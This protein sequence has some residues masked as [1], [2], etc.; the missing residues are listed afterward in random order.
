MDGELVANGTGTEDYFGTGWYGVEGRLDE[1]G[2]QAVAGV[3]VFDYGETRTRIAALRWHF[4]DP[5][6]YEWIDAVL[7]H[8][9]LNDT[10]AD[11]EAAIF[12]YSTGP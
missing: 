6:P 9:P 5:V 7:E 4:S 1:A 2:A 11:Y 10:P 3:P 8:G 12:F